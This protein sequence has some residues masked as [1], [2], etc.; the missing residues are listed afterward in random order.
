MLGRLDGGA[1]H[2]L[3]P[4]VVSGGLEAW[5]AV[6]GDREWVAV[7][8]LGDALYEQ[9]RRWYQLIVLRQD[10]TTLVLPYSRLGSLRHLKR[11]LRLVWPQALLG[12]VAVVLAT[13]VL[14]YL[15][16]SEDGAAWPESLLAAGGAWVVVVGSL[17]SRARNAAQ[18]WAT[19]LRQ[20][21]YTDLVAIDCTYVPDPPSASRWQWFRRRRAR[22]ETA[23]RQ[24]RLTPAT[25]VPDGS[26]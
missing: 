2:E 6:V 11:N 26:S 10:P 19:R 23:V 18:L 15:D 12:V 9:V 5:G 1:V 8:T 4:A 20:D 25:F 24:R 3:T 16:G 7:D 21:A 14:T 17:I 13:Y 22:V